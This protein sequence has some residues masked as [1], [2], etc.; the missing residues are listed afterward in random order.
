MACFSYINTS[1]RFGWL[2]IELKK[3]LI[4]SVVMSGLL[5]ILNAMKNGMFMIALDRQLRPV[6]LILFYLT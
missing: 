3:S 2:I 6:E 5:V 1:Y 4:P